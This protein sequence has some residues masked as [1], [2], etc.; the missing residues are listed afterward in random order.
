M[1]AIFETYSRAYNILQ[2][3]NILPNVFFTTSEVER[4]YC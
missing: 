2:F 1:T 3:A 4:D